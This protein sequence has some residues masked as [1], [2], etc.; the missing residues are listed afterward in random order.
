MSSQAYNSGVLVA[1][2]TALLV[3]GTEQVVAQGTLTSEKFKIIATENAE[4]LEDYANYTD[5]SIAYFDKESKRLDEELNGF[6]WDD[7]RRDGYDSRVSKYEKKRA[8]F[9]ADRAKQDL[10]NIRYRE[11]WAE[12][13][14]VLERNPA[15]KAL[16]EYQTLSRLVLESD[17]VLQRYDAWDR[18]AKR[19]GPVERPKVGTPP[20]TGQGAP[21]LGVEYEDLPFRV[22]VGAENTIAAR[23]VNN[24][25]HL[26]L[27]EVQLIKLS[28]N[29]SISPTGK[30]RFW[31]NPRAKSRPLSWKVTVLR[32][33]EHEIQM[34][35]QV[36]AYRESIGPGRQTGDTDNKSSFRV[37]RGQLTFDAEGQE[38]GTY[39]SRRPH[40]PGSP[41]KATQSG[42]TI[43]RGFDLGQW[44]REH[45]IRWLVAAGLSAEVAKKYAAAAGLRGADARSYLAKNKDDLPEITALQQ[46]RLFQLTFAYMEQDVRRIS[47]RKD[48]VDAYGGKVQ[49]DSLHPAIHAVLVDLRF[50]G[51]YSPATRPHVQR[52]VVR[53]DLKGFS[54]ALSDGKFWYG[55]NVPA[56]RFGRR[57]HFLDAARAKK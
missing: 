25:G 17:G 40:V 27:V 35:R 32:E 6:E 49:W 2:V 56:D 38:G 9:C 18:T 54:E 43:G 8:K 55:Q 50:R 12:S 47:D 39:H 5:K 19:P 11:L 48:V 13:K 45:I 34:N 21:I 57:V 20:Q 15:H 10:A 31:S 52:H 42:V 23:F 7:P 4:K 33:G 36:I 37:E 14:I 16:K 29:V 53:N 3:G 24:T 1:L 22:T 46:K 28:T 30:R 51:D 44:S 41:G 26:V